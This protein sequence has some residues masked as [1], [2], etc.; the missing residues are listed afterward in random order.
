MKCAVCNA[1]LG[2]AYFDVEFSTRKEYCV[3]HTCCACVDIL[4]H[5]K[6]RSTC[7]TSITKRIVPQSLNLVPL[8]TFAKP[9]V[10]GL[11]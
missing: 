1:E 5:R 11:F 4:A 3:M 9:Q 8:R 2:N 6:C 7:L 10:D